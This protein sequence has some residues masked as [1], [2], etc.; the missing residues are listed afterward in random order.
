MKTENKILNVLAAAGCAPA[1]LTDED[2]EDWLKRWR[3]VFARQL[4]AATGQWVLHDIDWHVFSYEHHQ[5]NS[6]DAA[7]AEYRRLSL[8]S[9]VVISGD[10]RTRFG[11]ACEGKPPD[12]LKAGVDIIV[13]PTSLDWTM[14]FTHEE[15]VFGPYFARP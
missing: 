4:H 6:G 14:V 5:A 11:F 1:A 9:F 7:W 3:A 10:G 8:C 2:V 12:R 13:A 15:P